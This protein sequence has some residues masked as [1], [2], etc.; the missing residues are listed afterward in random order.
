MRLTVR[1]A[2]LIAVAVLLSSCSKPPA[3][4]SPLAYAPADT[5]YVYGNLEAVPAATVEQLSKPMQDYWPTLF[6]LYETLLKDA[7]PAIDD[8]S[9]KIATALLEEIKTHNSWDKLRQIGLKPDA[10]V[11]LYGVGLVPVLR[12]ELGDAAA[13]K[14]EVARVEQNAGAKLPVA[15]TGDQEYWQPGNDTLSAAIAVQ[16]N[17]LVITAFPPKA[18]D[19]LKQA[20]LGVKRPDRS[21]A[22]AGTL[23][24]LAKQYS[25]SAYGEGF[26]DFVRLVEILSQPL[27]GSDAEFA[28][29][30]GLPAITSDAACRAEYLE[31]A[32]KFPRVVFGAEEMSG[33]RM[34]IAT[35]LEIDTRIAQQF[36]SAIGAAPGTGAA[37]EGAIDFSLALPV[38]KLKDFWIAQADAVAAKPYACATLHS[39]NEGFAT[40]K[41]KVDVVVPPPVSDLTGLRASVSKFELAH[42]ASTTPDVAGKL[43]LALSNPMTS[44]GIAQLAMPELQKIKIAADGKP[45]VLPADLL[46]PNA[47]PLTVAMSDKAIAFATGADDV[48]SLGTWL[49]AP[50]ATTPVFMRMHFSGAVYGW[51][52]RSLDTMKAA[53]PAD[54]Q[55]QF[56]LQTQMFGM[57]EKWLRSSDFTLTATP[58]GIRMQQAIELNS[59]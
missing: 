31:I 7:K 2:A 38:L 17:Y 39:L 49:A 11:A 53:M 4:D 24:A 22:D 23:Q 21:I 46:P 5:P 45:V 3:A 28:Q 58:T 44:V 19:A 56:Q 57:Y 36:A 26:V 41:A 48:A 16:G 51:M 29:A 6:D 27:S 8:T 52:S 14:A 9:Q 20:L 47:P 54:K 35:Q 15:R 42:G 40:S 37:S 12:M 43:L 10:R 50:A 25:Y 1:L 55:S 18:S 34:R 33:Q 30:L 59:P 32:H 13:F